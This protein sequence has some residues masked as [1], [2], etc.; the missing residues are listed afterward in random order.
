MPGDNDIEASMDN[1]ALKTKLKEMKKDGSLGKGGNGDNRIKLEFSDGNILIDGTIVGSVNGDTPEDYT[2]Y[3]DGNF[4][5]DANL[6]S[7]NSNLFLNSNPMKA[8]VFA[9]ENSDTVIMPMNDGEV[10]YE[11]RRA[12]KAGEKAK[13]SAEKEKNRKFNQTLIDLMGGPGTDAAIRAKAENIDSEI[14]KKT[15]DQLKNIYEKLT[16]KLDKIMDRPIK[17]AD[18]VIDKKTGTTLRSAYMH[19]ELAKRH[20]EVVEKVVAEL[21]KRGISVKKSLF[22]GFFDL[23]LIEEDIDDMEDDAEEESLWNDYSAEQP[24]LFNSTEFKVRE[25]MNRHYCNCL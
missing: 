13:K 21:E 4:L 25:A 1:K 23:E 14:A 7:N 5:L 22:D 3:M 18:S 19:T 9:D 16:F 17:T 6:E 24:E 10:D 15:D 20:P 8:V 2:V 11:A 12:E